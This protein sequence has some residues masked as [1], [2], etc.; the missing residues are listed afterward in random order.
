MLGPGKAEGLDSGPL[1]YGSLEVQL[2]AAAGGRP[3]GL[4]GVVAEAVAPQPATTGASVRVHGGR[5]T[6]PWGKGGR[7]FLRGI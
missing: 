3:D 6:H 4:L 2:E 1:A 5:A 7:V